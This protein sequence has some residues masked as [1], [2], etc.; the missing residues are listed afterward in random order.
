MT[1]SELHPNASTAPIAWT[2]ET[3]LYLFRRIFPQ[4]GYPCFMHMIIVGDEVADFM[5]PADAGGALATCI[6][7]TRPGL[8]YPTETFKDFRRYRLELESNK[9]VPPSY[10]VFDRQLDQIVREGR[11]IYRIRFCYRTLS[12]HAVS[13]LLADDRAAKVDE[14]LHYWVRHHRTLLETCGGF[15]LLEVRLKDGTFQQMEPE[16][17]NTELLE[18]LTQF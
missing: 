15:T 7:V 5:L 4:D 11:K 6:D 14:V 17:A 13:L 1:L 16:E 12:E 2:A 10:T 3:T 9:T 18:S 8:L